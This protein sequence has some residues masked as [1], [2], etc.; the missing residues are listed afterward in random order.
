MIKYERKI[1]DA[2]R[3][4]KVKPRLYKPGN[5]IQEWTD[6]GYVEWMFFGYM[7]TGEQIWH[8][9]IDNYTYTGNVN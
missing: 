9:E 2:L 3:L 4:K 5:R 6:Y 7:P 8:N 1:V